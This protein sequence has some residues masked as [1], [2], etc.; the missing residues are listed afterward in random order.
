MGAWCFARLK[1]AHPFYHRPASLSGEHDEESEEEERAADDSGDDEG[2]RS[3]S[4][5]LDAN[6]SQSSF[7]S[8]E[9]TGHHMLR[10]KPVKR[11]AGE[12]RIQRL[13]ARVEPVSSRC[14]NLF[15]RVS[16]CFQAAWTW[17]QLPLCT[18]CI[19]AG[20]RLR[21]RTVCYRRHHGQRAHASRVNLRAARL[22]CRP[23]APC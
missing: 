1:A 22:G 10:S 7:R 14:G 18:A 23:S 4:S 5:I 19:L 3:S 11:P 15:L 2:S 17:Q 12:N 6:L 16:F 9:Y 8:F 13:A 21:W 20:K